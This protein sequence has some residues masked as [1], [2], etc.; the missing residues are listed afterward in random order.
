MFKKRIKYV[1]FNG[2]PREEDFYFHMSPVEIT[3]LEAKIGGLTLDTYTK[4]LVANQDLAEMIE[5]VEDLVLSSYGEKSQ[6]GTRFMKGKQIREKFEYSQAYAELF[7]ELLTNPESANK[8]SAGIGKQTS[9]LLKKRKKHKEDVA[10]ELK[11]VDTD[12]EDVE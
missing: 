4:N 5:F 12:E 1:D 3:R 6:D 7:E 11:V 2:T 9:Q 8:F 10:T